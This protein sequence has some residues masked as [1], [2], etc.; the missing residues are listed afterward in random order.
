M[1]L[2]LV[3]VAAHPAYAYPQ[4][5]FVVVRSVNAIFFGGFASHWALIQALRVGVHIDGDFSLWGAGHLS[6]Y[7]IGGSVA[8]WESSALRIVTPEEL[9]YEVVRT[10]REAERARIVDQAY[11]AAHLLWCEN[12]SPHHPEDY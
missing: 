2:R 6:I 4:L 12:G 5:P 1:S 7:D 10:L 9:R 3:A 11:I 8:H